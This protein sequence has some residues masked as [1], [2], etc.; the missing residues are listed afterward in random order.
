MANLRSAYAE[1]SADLL[2]NDASNMSKTVSATQTVNGWQTN[3][4]TVNI[5]GITDVN[6]QTKGGNWN[7]HVGNN[8]NVAEVQI[9]TN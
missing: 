3:N 2:T 4:G 5:G 8:N 9:S 1:V 7:V 6:A